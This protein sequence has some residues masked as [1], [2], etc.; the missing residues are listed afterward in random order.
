MTDQVTVVMFLY[1]NHMTDQVTVVMFPYKNHM[2]DQATV[3]MLPYKD[4]MTD[5][6]TVVMLP[7]KNSKIYEGVDFESYLVQMYTEAD[8]GLLQHPR[9]NAL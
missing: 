5:Q 3:V 7:Y 6:V 8:L 1:K 2:T 4:H 9:W